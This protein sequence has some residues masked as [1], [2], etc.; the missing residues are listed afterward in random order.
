MNNNGLYTQSGGAASA[1]VVT[2]T[3]QMAA[4]GGSLT[5]TSIAQGT[6]LLSSTGR[7]NITPNGGD[8]GTSRVTA[9]SVTGTSKLDLSDNDLVVDRSEERRVGKECRSRWSP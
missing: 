4:S 6:L 5:A 9:V 7:V 3:G 2:G 1:G 8:A